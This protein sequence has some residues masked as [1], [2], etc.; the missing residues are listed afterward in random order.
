[1]FK[2]IYNNNILSKF[3]LGLITFSFILGTAIMWGPGGLNLLGTPYIVKVGDVTITPK[4]YLLELNKFRTEYNIPDK[5]LKRE[6]LNNLIILAILVYLSEN[7]GFYVSKKEIEDFIRK[8]F[9]TK[10]GK[11]NF[12]LFQEYLKN[13]RLTPEFF[14]EIVKKKLEASKY[15]KAIYSTSYTNNIILEV[16]TLPF[17]IQL[18]VKLYKLTYKDINIKISPSEEELK[19]FY[20]QLKNKFYI[21]LPPR[22]EIF[23]AKT[24]EEAKEIVKSLK[25]GKS[26]KPFKIISLNSTETGNNTALNKLIQKI[27]NTKHISIVEDK[28]YY[29]VGIYKSEEKKKVNFG[30]IKPKLIELY[31]KYKTIQW[32]HKNLSLF[33]PQILSSKYKI[34]PE[35][36]KI[37]GYELLEKF[38]LNP[39]ILF[40]ILKGKKII[41]LKTPKGIAIIEILSFTKSKDIPQDIKQLYSL[42]IRKSQY[43]QKLQ[44]VLNFVFKSNKVKIEINKKLIN[45]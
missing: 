2:W 22:L 29:L 40:Q 43:L 14:E 32:L 21:I 5:E 38:N 16:I 11:F 37:L 18:N 1:M 10:N 45:F 13:L 9:S 25:S 15:K 24:L 33:T 20:N 30:E 4:E 23:K 27:K 34:Q 19:R 6:V 12:S 36:K 28:N 44:E 3:F 31:K 39:E 8:M 26:L 7:D 35:T 41:S 17:L 42:Q